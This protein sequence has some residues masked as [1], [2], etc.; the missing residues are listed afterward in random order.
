MFVLLKPILFFLSL[1]FFLFV[2]LYLEM[3]FSFLF[4]ENRGNTMKQ[5]WPPHL[6]AAEFLNFG[7]LLQNLRNFC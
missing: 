1:F 6:D 2:P 7:K 5:I 4:D 3:R